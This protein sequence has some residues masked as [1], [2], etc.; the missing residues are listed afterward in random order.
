MRLYEYEAKQILAEQGLAVP[1]GWLWPGLPAELPARLVVKAQTLAGGRG[2]AGG[3]RFI[4]PEGGP[5]REQVAAEV[6]HLLGRPIGEQVVERVYV[7]EALAVERELY[8]AA[9]VDRDRRGLLFLA[10]RQ[11][12][13]AVEAGDPASFTRVEVDPLIGLMPYQERRLA[14]GLGLPEAPTAAAQR[15]FGLLGAALIQLDAEL[16]EINPLVLTADGSLVAADARLVVDDAA[17]A[18]QPALPRAAR[19]GSAFEQRCWELGVAG[20]ELD[21]DIAMVIS[22]AG[23]GMASVD[24]VAALGGSTRA[25]ID[26]GGTAFQDR[27]TLDRVLRLA[28]ELQPKVLLVQAYFQLA[29]LGPLA[30][31]LADV[32]REPGPGRPPVVARLKGNDEAEARRILAPAG[33][34]LTSSLEVAFASAVRLARDPTARERQV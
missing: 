30:E 23:L 5:I 11:G 26:L 28:L 29:R 32:L 31:A 21:G 19:F 13:A 15:L 10:G 27:V 22:G 24:S 7:E 8:A 33:I 25:L 9:L 17:L 16:I 1:R 3:V 6:D 18:R 2:L 4:G 34:V 12:G 20:T 14:A